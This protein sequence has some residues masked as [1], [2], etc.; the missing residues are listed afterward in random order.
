MPRRLDPAIPTAQATHAAADEPNPT[1]TATVAGT[2][3]AG[4]AAG[5]ITA[6]G[7]NFAGTGAGT[8]SIT[9]TLAAAT[10]FNT[11]A[12]SDLVVSGAAGRSGAAA[13]GAA[14][15]GP[16]ST[17]PRSFHMMEQVGPPALGLVTTTQNGQ[18]TGSDS[19]P[20]DISGRS[21]GRSMDTR[22]DGIASPDGNGS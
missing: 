12:S 15:A 4:T 1:I 7:T 18:S 10:N 8:S 14:G 16:P 2:N 11:S 21:S 20:M 3:F 22:S 6:A 5:T 19:E 13:S 9:A 17:R